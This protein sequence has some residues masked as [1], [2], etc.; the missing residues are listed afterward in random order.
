MVNKKKALRQAKG[1]VRMGVCSS[2]SSHKPDSPFHAI[3]SPQDYPNYGGDGCER[4]QTRFFN[5]QNND[6]TLAAS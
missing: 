6:P 1:L 5:T 2:D 4:R 3:P